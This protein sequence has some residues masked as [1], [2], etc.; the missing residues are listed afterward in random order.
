M[1]RRLL[2]IAATNLRTPIGRQ[3]IAG[4]LFGAALLIAT[5]ASEQISDQVDQAAAELAGYDD[6]IAQRQ[7]ELD[8]I[9][10]QVKRERAM[11]AALQGTNAAMQTKTPMVD[12]EPPKATTG[13]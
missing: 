10:G 1:T 6:L 8:S 13:T 9:A 4:L 11:L 7:R 5:K 12:R 2:T 3:A